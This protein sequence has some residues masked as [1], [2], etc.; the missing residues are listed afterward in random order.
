[1]GLCSS[2]GFVK[3]LICYDE[4]NYVGHK[5][6]QPIKTDLVCEQEDEN[7]K[8]LFDECLK[9]LVK[10]EDIR[11][12]IAEKFRTLFIETGSCVL[13][14]P[15][16]ERSI[17]SF[18]ACLMIHLKRCAKAKSV[19]IKDIQFTSLFKIDT[20]PPFF[21]IDNEE[22]AKLKRVYGFDMNE[23]ECLSK[24]KSAIIECLEAAGTTKDILATQMNQ[25]SLLMSSIKYE[26]T[27]ITEIKNMYNNISALM[28]QITGTKKTLELVA[29]ILGEISSGS[30]EGIENFSNPKKMNRLNKIAADAIEKEIYDPKR[31]VFNYADGDKCNELE[32]WEENLSYREIDELLL[33]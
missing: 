19:E 13:K 9:E 1:M 28:N 30:V 8:R 32:D 5:I 20:N 6:F 23:I 29:D 2:V 14:H 12:G 3:D 16:F 18:I 11:K 27:K 26:L 33:Y 22:V 15:T 31:I 17:S 25:L 21:H 7:I 4:V 24:G 10:C